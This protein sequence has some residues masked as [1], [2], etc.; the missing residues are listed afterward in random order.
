[1]Y[2]TDGTEKEDVYK[3]KQKQKQKLPASGVVVNLAAPVKRRSSSKKS[4]GGGS[5]RVSA[6]VRPAVNSIHPPNTVPKLCLRRVF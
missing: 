3:S 6:P 4:S 2:N 1:V 5:W